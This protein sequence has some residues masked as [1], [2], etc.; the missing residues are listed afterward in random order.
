M[1]VIQITPNE[2][3]LLKC[4]DENGNVIAPKTRKELHTRPYRI[5]HGVTAVWLLN[6]KGKI[7]CT[8]RSE[9]NEGNPGKWQ[10]Y[11]GGH[12]KA[13]QSFLETAQTELTEELGLRLSTEHFRL[14]AAGKREDVMHVFEMYAVLFNEDLSILQF[15]DGE[16]DDATW[17]T[18]NDYQTR[19]TN[20]PEIWCNSM[21]LEQYKKVMEV[22]GI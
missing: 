2:K 15:K 11:V 13:D 14:V 20:N 16:I 3:E 7:L 9:K 6:N 22:L 17:F 10:T 1:F 12:V 18:F 19:K 21:K 8:R 5:W 4:F